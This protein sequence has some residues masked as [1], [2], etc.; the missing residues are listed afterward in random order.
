MPMSPAHRLSRAALGAIVSTGV[1]L[2]SHVLGGGQMPAIAG[3]AV[4]LLL[5]FA[6]CVQ[7]A[8]RALSLWRLAT[9]V[10]VSQGLFH[11]LFVLGSGSATMHGPHSHHGGPVTV[12][13][14]GAVGHGAHGGVVMTLAHVGAAVLTTL[15]LHHAEALLARGALLAQWLRTI[16]L[17]PQPFEL[18]VVVPRVVGPTLMPVTAGV[19]GD[20]TR[21]LFSP[22]GPPVLR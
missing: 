15:A 9:A 14:A 12:T 10:S 3:W 16:R 7:F 8:G 19:L 17:L 1:A 11:L 18:P 13:S 4:P 6:V 22:R 21:G 5:S 2:G 20:M